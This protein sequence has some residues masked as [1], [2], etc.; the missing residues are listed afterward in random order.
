M[1]D[2]VGL[3]SGLATAVGPV[4]FTDPSAAADLALAGDFELLTVPSAGAGLHSLLGQ[5]VDGVEGLRAEST[6]MLA[7]DPDRLDLSRS[8]IRRAGT[9][10]AAFETLH[11]F[12]DRARSLTQVD[13]TIVGVRVPLTGPVTLT[14]AMRT[15]GVDLDA[16]RDFAGRLVARRAVK[17]LS[18][19]RQ[20]LPGHVVVMCLNE[21]GLVGAAH[22][23]FPLGPG[24]VLELLDPVVQ[25]LDGH[26]AA[27][28]L[29]IGAHVPGHTD[30]ETVI[31]SGVSLISTPVS[32]ALSGWAEPLAE[33]L[34]L[35]GRIAWGAVPVDQPL[36]SSEELLWRR[37]SAVWCELVA[38]GIDPL[39]LRTQ[40]LVSPVD[41][42]GH[43]GATQAELALRLVRSL[44]TR[45]GRQAV[46]ARLSLG[47]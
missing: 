23:T 44:S 39:V 15:A 6:G 8:T 31:A 2:M 1:G 33:F 43:F 41:G 20:R 37:L 17:L 25:A 36:G 46:A 18:A 35:G 5:A 16:A 21:P 19:V 40:S 4:P 42:L 24:E 28:Q 29:L 45:V 11:L 34:G 47:A 7:V 12:L 3:R 38:E 27:G 32:S 14:L 10:G 9:S 13:R 26:P 30:W 22:P